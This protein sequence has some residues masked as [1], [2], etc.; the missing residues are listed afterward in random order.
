MDAVAAV[1]HEPALRIGEGEIR[2]HQDFGVGRGRVGECPDEG[3]DI[4]GSAR[5]RAVAEQ[6][7]A[8]H[9]SEE[10]QSAILGIEAQWPGEPVAHHQKAVL[11]QV[12]ADT[13]TFGL[14][15]DSERGQMARFADAGAL[16]QLR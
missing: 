12:P 4:I 7:V 1:R 2:R 9:V 6:I 3:S 11:E 10:P 15:F 16:Q 5:H 14:H 13:R 8:Q